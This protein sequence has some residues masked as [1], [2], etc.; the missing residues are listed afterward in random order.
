MITQQELQG[1][2]NE[3]KGRLQERWGQLT[4]DDLKQVRGSVNQLVGTVQR[5]TGESREQIEKFLDSLNEGGNSTL[6]RATQE[7]RQYA[8]QVSGALQDQYAHASDAVVAG[9]EEAQESVRRHP[10]ESVAVAFG[11][12]LIAGAVLGLVLR[13][14]H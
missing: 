6:D 4:D 2:W 1:N 7:A 9:F 13:P 10:A 11:A 12:G 5:K 14:R 8:A 3:I